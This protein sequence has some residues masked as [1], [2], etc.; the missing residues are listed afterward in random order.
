MGG[1]GLRRGGLREE[2][3]EGAMRE[4]MKRGMRKGGSGS[5]VKCEDIRG[6]R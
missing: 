6:G 5:D 3:W 1:R 4:R 2:E